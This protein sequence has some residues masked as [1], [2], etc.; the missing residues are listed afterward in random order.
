MSAIYDIGFPDDNGVCRPDIKQGSTFVLYLMLYDKLTTA[1]TVTAETTIFMNVEVVYQTTL[2][3]GT[4]LPDGTA[5][6]AP[7]VLEPGDIIYAGTFLI[8][9]T[10]I[11]AGTLFPRNI[12][13]CTPSAQFRTSYDSPTSYPFSAL[14]DGVGVNGRIKLVMPAA[15]SATIPAPVTGVY[16]CELLGLDGVTVTPV[17]EG[18]A[19][20]RPEVTR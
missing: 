12:T 3:V 16:D 2:P 4:V 11:P 1:K 9:G 7:L 17:I 6:T 18:K 20:V 8:V 19:K 14:I 13:G 5:L 10:V 15:I